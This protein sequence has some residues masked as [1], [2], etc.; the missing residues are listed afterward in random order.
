MPGH[1]VRY[2]IWIG[3]LVVVA[4][5]A[6]WYLFYSPGREPIQSNHRGATVLLQ[7]PHAPHPPLG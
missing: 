3:V 6:A 7:L 4:I 2:L 1:V 5:A